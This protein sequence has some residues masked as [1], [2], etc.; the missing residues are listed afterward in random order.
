MKLLERASASG[1]WGIL[2]V[3]YIGSRTSYPRRK[4]LGG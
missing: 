1:L 2:R 3:S 4:S